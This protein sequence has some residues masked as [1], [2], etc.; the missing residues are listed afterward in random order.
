MGYCQMKEFVRIA[1]KPLLAVLLALSCSTS[2]WGYDFF[3]EGMRLFKENKHAEAA[4]LLYKA[5]LAANADPRVFV[6]LGIAYRQLEKYPDAI[7]TFI[8]GTQAAGTDRK[9]LFFNAGY[10]YY[11]QGQYQEAESMYTKAIELDSAWAPP[12]VNRANARVNLQQFSRAIEDYN[13]YL[14]LDPATWQRE[15]IVQLIALLS[16]EEQNRVE[17]SRRAEAARVASEAEKAA[18]AER[19]KRLMDEVSASLQAVDAASTRS[20]GSESVLDYDEEGQLE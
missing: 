10:V 12:F 3:A 5:S 8:R 16:V 11:I 13:A 9:A 19:M 4:P 2:V 1:S 15:Q 20:A 18:Q 6:Y 14:T 7:S 17:A